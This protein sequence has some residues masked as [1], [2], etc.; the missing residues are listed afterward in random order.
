MCA[1]IEEIRGVVLVDDVPA[2]EGVLPAHGLSIFLEVGYGEEGEVS[3]LI[4][5]GHSYK[6]LE[7]NAEALGVELPVDY[8][9]ATLPLFHHVGAAMQRRVAKHYSLPPRLG[10]EARLPPGF[11]ETPASGYWGE[12]GL[13][14]SIGG[15]KVFF[16]GCSVHGLEYT[17][18]DTLEGYWG[19]IGGLGLSMRDAHGLG[20]LRKLV[21]GGL[22]VVFPLHSVSVEAREHILG[23]ILGGRMSVEMTGV[24]VEFSI[25]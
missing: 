15:R 22:E 3:M 18:G 5:S 10:G 20:F 11:A 4:D 9:Y 16:A 1:L 17:W 23:N 8:F 24:G 12:R 14:V 13:T 25:R 2:V 21:E 19:L 7:R 6:L